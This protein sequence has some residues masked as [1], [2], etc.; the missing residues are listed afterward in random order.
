MGTEEQ[1]LPPAGWYADPD[2]GAGR[3]R[4]WDGTRWTEHRHEGVATTAPGTRGKRRFTTLHVIASVYFVLG[5]LVAVLGGIGVIV[6]AIEQA[7]DPTRFDDAEPAA[8]AILGALYVA[9]IALTLIAASAFIR[10]M[11]SVEDSTR[12]TAA[13]VE[14]LRA[15]REPA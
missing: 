14:T 15:E 1:N 6:A 2:G 7:D 12:R 4:Y 13:A 11:L 3:M 5:I 9:F 10:L 8:V